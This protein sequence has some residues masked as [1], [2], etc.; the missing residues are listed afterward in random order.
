MRPAS[1]PTSEG[2]AASK[3][4]VSGA[5]L[6]DGTYTTRP[7]TG[8]PLVDREKAGVFARSVMR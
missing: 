1:G 2:N 3:L 8:V 4:S 6:A 7:R 5:P